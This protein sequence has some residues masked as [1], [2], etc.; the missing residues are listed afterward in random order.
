MVATG[1]LNHL[2][3][4]YL[5]LGVMYDVGIRFH[6][7]LNQDFLMTAYDPPR[8]EKGVKDILPRVFL[9][10]NTLEKDNE[11]RGFVFA[12]LGELEY[13]VGDQ[14]YDGIAEEN[15]YSVPSVTECRD[16]WTKPK[17]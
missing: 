1:A 5:V 7:N 16:V 14:Y 11:D 8:N 15:A 17:E 2:S 12:Q 9:N 3:S 6:L 10:V 4:D 13:Y